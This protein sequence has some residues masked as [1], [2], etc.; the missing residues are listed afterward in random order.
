MNETQ[1][2]LVL[3]VIAG[4]LLLWRVTVMTGFLPLGAT[5]R[6]YLE[7]FGVLRRHRWILLIFLAGTG[8]SLLVNGTRQALAMRAHRQLLAA[9]FQA[10]RD[11]GVPWPAVLK[12][13]G[14][15]GLSA[16]S[17]SVWATP[18]RSVGLWLAVVTLVVYRRRVIPQ[19]LPADC[20]SPTTARWLRWAIWAGAGAWCAWIVIQF[21]TAGA[22]DVLPTQRGFVVAWSILLQGLSLLAAAFWVVTSAYLACGLINI[23]RQANTTGNARPGQLLE[24]TA[25]DFRQLLNFFVFVTA[26]TGVLPLL[27]VQ[28]FGRVRWFQSVFKVLPDLEHVFTLLVFPAMFLIVLEQAAW[29]PAVR[30]T[31][32]LWRRHA[33]AW[34][35]LL[36]PVFTL[37]F[38]VNVLR[39]RLRFHILPTSS[40]WLIVNAL[41]D[42]IG[43][44]ASAWWLVTIVR[45]WDST[46]TRADR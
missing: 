2:P 31:V 39:Q 4:L 29:R 5:V 37:A 20:V 13:A 42:I 32:A 10:H 26:I 1:L 14:R 8:A 12:I 35:A 19:I 16:T 3:T 18:C 40:A 9:Q 21:V 28:V 30:Q 41:T 11:L 46:K 6:L 15:Q 43:A 17:S 36:V 25:A 34:L 24:V 45:W 23:A 27:L 33:G 22:A 38:A 7:S 44:L